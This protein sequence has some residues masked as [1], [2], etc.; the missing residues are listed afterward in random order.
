MKIALTSDLHGGYS[1]KTFKIHEGWIEELMELDYEILILAG[2][3]G[4]SK[5]KDFTVNEFIGGF[6]ALLVSLPS[7]IAYG[8]IIFSG[9]GESYTRQAAVVGIIGTIILSIFASIFG[10]TP[11]MISAPSA[12]AGAV[13]SAYVMEL[14]HRK[15][16]SIEYV[17]I[18]VTLTALFAMTGRKYVV[19]RLA[20]LMLWLE[21]RAP[22]SHASG[23]IDFPF[24]NEDLAVI[25]GCAREV[26][27]R[28]RHLLVDSGAI[29]YTRRREI[30]IIDMPRLCNIRDSGAGLST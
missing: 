12:P 21:D 16:V 22:F 7:A 4:T 5:L 3:I 14:V 25:M 20:G 1:E 18:F 13:L 15:N 30:R 17:P 28:T 9:L 26:V 24:R 23:R 19:S 8:L 6:S 2:D 10:K 27:S 11:G 29:T